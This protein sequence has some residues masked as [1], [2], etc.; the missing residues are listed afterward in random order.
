MLIDVKLTDQNK[1]NNL[2]VMNLTCFQIVTNLTHNLFQHFPHGKH[3]TSYFLIN[4]T[5]I[6][7]FNK[8]GKLGGP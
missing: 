3:P 2:I 6:T 7:L 5:I 4:D 8:V 1:Q